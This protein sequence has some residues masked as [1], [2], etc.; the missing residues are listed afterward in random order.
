MIQAVLM[1]MLASLASVPP[2]NESR[3]GPQCQ[4]TGKDEITITCSYTA[5]PRSA[6]YG[7]RDLSVA[8]NRASLSLKT[9]DANDMQVELTFTNI[10]SAPISDALTVY[11]AI[12]DDKAN[13]YVRRTLPSVDFR[14][15][16]PGKP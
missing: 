4:T 6:L 12:D 16:M 1:A 15:L 14:K 13:N 9:D 11:L 10:G 5:K 2:A 3:S 7:K 8:L